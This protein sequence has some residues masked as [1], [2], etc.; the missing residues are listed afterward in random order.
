MRAQTIES[1]EDPRVEVY[2]SVRDPELRRRGLFMVEGRTN[3]RLLVERS[4]FAPRSVFVTPAGLAGIGD[5][6]C[7]LPPDTPVYVASQSV[8]NDVVGYNMHR[9][10]LAAAGTRGACELSDLVD[11]SEFSDGSVAGDRTLGPDGASL[12]I[13]LEQVSDPMNVG[14]IFRNAVAFGSRGVALCPRCCDPLY[15]QVVRVSMGAALLLPFARCETWPDPLLALRDE[16]YRVVALHPGEEAVDIREFAARSG[17]FQN[18]GA[19]R[20]VLVLGN[21]GRGLSQAVLD[22]ADERVRIGMAPGVDSIN[23]ATAAGIA[24]HQLS[25]MGR[26]ASRP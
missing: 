15:R 20:L 25:G 22:L 13:A 1:L 23:I 4:R 16:G 17:A 6:L 9:G 26:G 14:S 10:V 8:L 21:E 11:P 2:R 12:L 24:L 18:A 19:D 5:A 3:V 7:K